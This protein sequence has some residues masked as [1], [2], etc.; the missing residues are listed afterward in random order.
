MK[1]EVCPLPPHGVSLGCSG[2]CLQIWKMDVTKC[3][4]GVFLHLVVWLA[5]PYSKKKL[6]LSQISQKA[7]GMNKL[8]Q[9]S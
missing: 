4:Q 1:V 9:F 5:T 2:V 8:F 6:G 3:C 7:T